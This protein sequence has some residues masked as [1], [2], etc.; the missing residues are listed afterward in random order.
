[1]PYI[2]FRKCVIVDGQN[3]I[4]A[5]RDVITVDGMRPKAPDVYVYDDKGVGHFTDFEHLHDAQ[6]N[7]ASDNEA[8]TGIWAVTDNIGEFYEFNDAALI[9]YKADHAPVAN[10]LYIYL[11]E[12]NGGVIGD[13]DGPY[14]GNTNQRYYHKTTRV[15]TTVTTIIYSD[16]ARTN[17]LDTLT[18]T[19][20]G[21]AYQYIYGTFSLDLPFE[22]DWYGTIRYFD[23]QEEAY[24]PG[25]IV[26]DSGFTVGGDPNDMYID[27]VSYGNEVFQSTFDVGDY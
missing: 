7:N 1:M 10:K 12:A 17:I 5:D 24:K 18:I 13:T 25:E 4:D 9:Y 27:T 22:N 16:E 3:C 8:Y 26:L 11:R 23:L 15:G 6:C 14:I 19:D 21:N 20:T 2:D